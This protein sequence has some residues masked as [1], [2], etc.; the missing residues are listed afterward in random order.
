MSPLVKFSPDDPTGV[1][2]AELKQHLLL[3]TA[4][5]PGPK[6]A[7]RVLDLYFDMW[8]DPFVKYA[9][10]AFG[11]G[12]SEWNKPDRQRFLSSE[13]PQ[14]RQHVD[15][16]Y[17]FSDGRKTDSWMLMFHGYRPFTDAGKA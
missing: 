5:P 16:G 8:G 10:T 1:P 4:S 9:S 13:L 14:L 11:S 7:R 15:W 17:S 12:P 3:F 2:L 6:T